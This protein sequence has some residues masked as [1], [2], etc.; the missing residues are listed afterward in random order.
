MATKLELECKLEM[1]ERDIRREANNEG[2]F[3]F[4][5]QM[6]MYPADE[7]KNKET[8][9]FFAARKVEYQKEAANL[10]VAI[11]SLC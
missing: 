8:A 2:A 9:R 10:R 5:A 6:S 11:A 7:E 1:V 4:R 3:A